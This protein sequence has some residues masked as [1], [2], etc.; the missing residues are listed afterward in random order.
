MRFLYVF[1]FRVVK[2]KVKIRFDHSLDR[3]FTLFQT[4][5]FRLFKLK[6]FVGNKFE[7]DEN[8]RK[9]SKW[10]ENTVGK[11]EIT[12][13][14]QFL[15]FPTVFSKDLYCRHI[16]KPGLDLMNSCPHNKFLDMTKFKAKAHDKCFQ[17]I[18]FLFIE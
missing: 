4:T 10:I 12:H 17:K 9:F 5:N 16:K 11:G 15:L 6:E 13:Y 8:G 3:I 14:E 7:L 1:L 18:Y 2:I